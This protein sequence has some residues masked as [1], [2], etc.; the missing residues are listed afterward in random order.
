MSLFHLCLFA[1]GWAILAFLP[2]KGQNHFPRRVG[3]LGLF[4]GLLLV[5]GSLLNA[6]WSCVVYGRFYES[7]DYVFGFLPFWPLT[8]YWIE[9][10]GDD[11]QLMNVPLQL[12]FIWFVFT[13]STWGFTIFLYRLVLSP[14]WR[15]RPLKSSHSGGE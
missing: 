11:G 5:V 9:M 10:H 7:S 2:G 6:L 4:L 14:K 15:P 1:V 12:Q 8:K 3:R 13:A